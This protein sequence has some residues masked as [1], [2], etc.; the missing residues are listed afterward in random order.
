MRALASLLAGIS[1]T[2]TLSSGLTPDADAQD[3][4]YGQ[5]S[6][7]SEPVDTY[8][9]DELVDAVSDFFGVTAEAAASVLE[10][11]FSDL[12]R[13]VGYVA[14]EE[15]AAAAGIGLRYGEGYLTLK[16][17]EREKV[18]WRGPSIG[19]DAGGNASRVFVLVY[20]LNDTDRLYQRFP[21]VEG[22]AYF[23]AGMGVNYQRADEITLAPI[24][25]GVGL[26]AGANVGYLAY[27]RRRA[28]LP[29]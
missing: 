13:P 27:S 2:F 3:P 10:R 9:Q 20:N 21:G 26:R 15:V 25:S 5:P 19:F 23:V 1:L 18:Y 11:V 17:G 14:G 16:S 12:G 4:D 24:R 6:E 8:S 29:F 22:S 7:Y 28:W